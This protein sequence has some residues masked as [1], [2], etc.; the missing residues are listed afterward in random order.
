MLQAWGKAGECCPQ[1][2]VHR[3]GIHGAQR[4]PQASVHGGRA[5]VGLS[6]IPMLLC[7]EGRHLWGSAPSP[8]FC[9]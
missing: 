9:A 7:M 3:V 5:S 1:A 6:V 8:G 2:P 4:Q